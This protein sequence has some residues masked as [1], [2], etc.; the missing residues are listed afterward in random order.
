MTALQEWRTDGMLPVLFTVVLRSRVHVVRVDRS[1]PHM[2]SLSLVDTRALC[3]VC[4]ATAATR[5]C[6]RLPVMATCVCDSQ[7]MRRA[8][9]D[10]GTRVVGVSP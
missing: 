7:L 2:T 1:R 8:G 4:S 9:G 6:S 5:S 3:V 10:E